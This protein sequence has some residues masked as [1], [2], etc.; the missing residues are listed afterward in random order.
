MAWEALAATTQPALDRLEFKMKLLASLSQEDTQ[1]TEKLV[2]DILDSN[3]GV[4]VDLLS[5]HYAIVGSTTCY[6]QFSLLENCAQQSLALADPVGIAASVNC[7]IDTLVLAQLCGIVLM[8]KRLDP[9]KGSTSG[10]GD[11]KTT[12][13]P[14]HRTTRRRATP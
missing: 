6:G 13:R 4:G 1:T 2:D 10:R 3:S 5:L 11:G 8:A 14:A 7:V 9:Q 12:A